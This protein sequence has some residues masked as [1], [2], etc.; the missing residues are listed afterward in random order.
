MTPEEA[1]RRR[2]RRIDH[3]IGLVEGGVTLT[4]A[5][6]H[7]L[8]QLNRL[9]MM[10]VAQGAA[11]ETLDREQEADGVVSDVGNGAE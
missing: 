11:R 7:R 1:I 9:E 5:D 8:D 10:S 3:L 2:K 6:W 4:Q